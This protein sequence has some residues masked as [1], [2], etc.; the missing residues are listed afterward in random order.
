[1]TSSKPAI[2][3]DYGNVLLDWDAHRIFRPYF[4]G[5]D[6]DIDAFFA[7]ISFMEWH[8]Q[9]DAGRPFAEAIAELSAR[10][11]Q[12]AHILPDYDTR[13]ADSISGPIDGTVEILRRLKQ[14]GLPLYG[15]SNYP[16]E[17]FKLDRPKY[18]FFNW[19]DDMVISGEVRLSKP[20]P[21]IFQLLL[22]KIG[23]RAQEC[24]FIDDS[25]ANITTAR[26]L[27]FTAI[28]FQSPAQLEQELH[29][30]GIL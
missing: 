5:G 20:D 15:L 17:K 14:A 9:Q 21:A 26:E 3:F 25:H 30:L 27:G 4:P 22:K 13:Y 12:Y 10:F 24:I 7:E 28:Q 16:A 11:P 8:R 6:K 19:F 18:E 23:R 29:S 2:I 1:M